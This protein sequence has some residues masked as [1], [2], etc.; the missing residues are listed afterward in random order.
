MFF[1]KKIKFNKHTYKSFYQNLEEADKMKSA[2]LFWEVNNEQLTIMVIISFKAIIVKNIIG[3]PLQINYYYFPKLI[4]KKED[5]NLIYDLVLKSKNNSTL[6]K[7]HSLV[8]IISETINK[9]KIVQQLNLEKQQQLWSELF[10]L[11]PT[12]FLNN[13][14]INL[15]TENNNWVD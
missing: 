10:L 1:L 14:L 13:D 6:I 4:S 12:F 7:S 15:S 2:V 9:V 11:Q 5:F 3:Q 8:E